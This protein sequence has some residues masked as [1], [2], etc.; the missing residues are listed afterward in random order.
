M[1]LPRLAIENRVFT[2]MVMIGL[3]LLGIRAYITMPRTE[4][5]EVTVPGSSVIVVMPGASSMDMENMVALPVEE[6]LNELED[7]TRVSTDLRDGLAVISVEFEFDTDEDEKYEEVVRQ[8]NSIRSQLPE[9]ILQLET[10]QWSVADMNMMQ[11]ALVSENS[12]FAELEDLA[13]DLRKEVEKIS[14]IRKVSYYG[15]PSREIHIGLDFEK[16]AMVHTSL[17]HITRAIE[18]NNMNIPAGDLDIGKT[19]LTVKSSG[20]FQDLDEIRNCVVNSYEG[21][22]IYLRDV[23]TVEYG[24][25]D[26]LYLTRHNSQRC[27][28]IGISQKE[29]LN[30]LKTSEALVPLLDSF[31]E[32]L[33]EGVSLAVIYDQP[34]TV[35]NRINGFVNNLLQGMVLV[36]LVI[37]LSLGFRSSIVVALAI[38]LSLLIGLG[39]LD[40]SGYGLQQISIAAMVVVLGMLVDNS[41]VVV[42]NINRYMKMGH[43]RKEASILAVSEIGWPVVT[44]TLT[45]ILAFVPIA[46]MQGMSG[47]FIRS[48]PL[49]IMFALLVSLLI[50]LTFT[51]VIT[52]GLFRERKDPEKKS[53]GLGR[54]LAWVTEK[55][56]RAS[57]NA[58]LRRPAIFLIP[59]LVYLAV[60][61][62]M[63]GHLGISFFPKAEQPNLMIQ[64][65][66]PEGSGLARTDEATRYVESVLDTIP[67]VRSYSSNV[68]QGNPRIYYN[69]FTHRSDKKFA[70]IYVTLHS[71]EPDHFAQ[72]IQD[73]RNEFEPFPGARIQV[74]EFEQGPPY[75]APV[76]IFLTGKNLEGLR[77]VSA[78][79][80]AMIRKQPG[81][82][83]IENKF[84]K[85]ST[86]LLFDINKEKANM[87]GVPVIGIDRTIR[88]VVSG[89]QVSSFRDPSGEEFPMVLKMKEVKDFRV[90]DLDR[91]YVSSLSGR[92]IPIRHFVDL[93]M[94]QVPSSIS[95]FDLERTAEILAGLGP[96]YSLDEVMEPLLEELEDYPFPAGFSYHVSGE[97]E[98]RNDAFG[99]MTNAIIIAVISI[100]SILVLQFR[101][102]KQP[103][104]VFIAIPFAF[105][106]MV[107]ALL[108][109]GN[110]FSFTAFVGLTSLVGIVVNNSIIL[111]DY[112]NI[113]RKRGEPLLTALQVAAETRLKPIMLT[114]LTTIGGLIP[115]TLRGGT[116]WAPMGWTIIGGLLVSTLIT[117]IIIPV[118]YLLLE[119]KKNTN[120]ELERN[121]KKPSGI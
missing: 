66:L 109:T 112:I 50:A 69:V 106:G 70:E 59:A 48:L 121:E 58:S 72:L 93:K 27:I 101:S 51:P 95:R 79:V 31:R 42:E 53:R 97:M 88:T 110:T 77:K 71:Y 103:L 85:T 80:E 23:A 41:I 6:A 76:Q 40:L 1:I 25:E 16:M 62:Y 78:D 12:S 89:L 30:V 43:P 67:D 56:F 91:V 34:V 2:W 5:P 3:T 75:D 73:L 119:R 60:S 81:A 54:L 64:V 49:T 37:L 13:E 111:V 57:L 52:S 105:T 63:F 4:N 65:T 96:G 11:L 21:R 118:T 107:W 83:N 92:Q 26:R 86:Q 38:P 33:P 8:I 44:A 7:I 35:R 117:V 87:L 61:A 29:G 98:G 45:T 36:A 24:Y 55:P 20:S 47:E 84:V 9:S 74:R 120:H 46:A 32:G 114:A 99:G 108:A 17:D 68:G 94:Q 14:S 90:E 22:L 18:T 116:M 39:F 100:F 115:L 10:W 19:S 113:L 28:F 15:L 102:V 104:L 82:I